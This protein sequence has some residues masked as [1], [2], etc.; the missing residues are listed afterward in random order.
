[1]IRSRR[2]SGP[3]GQDR[4][5]ER[6]EVYGALHPD[7]RRYAKTDYP[8]FRVLNTGKA[9]PWED[10]RYRREGEAELQ[11]FEVTSAPV[12]D[13]TDEIMTIVTILRDVGVERTAK[14]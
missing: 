11:L 5:I 3:L 4:S 10:M 12:H 6:Y 14:C 9:V 8:S 2:C 1:M 7:G 13:A